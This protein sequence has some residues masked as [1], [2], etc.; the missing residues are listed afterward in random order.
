MASPYL[1]KIIRA[2]SSFVFAFL[3]PPLHVLYSLFLCT[4]RL[5]FQLLFTEFS[6]VFRPIWY[7]IEAYIKYTSVL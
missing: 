7:C 5:Y 1:R 3:M 4:N 2:L 6:S